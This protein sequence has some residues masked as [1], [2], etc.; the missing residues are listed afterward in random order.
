MTVSS[1]MAFGASQK[2]SLSSKLR[3]VSNSDDTI[4]K[5]EN[6]SHKYPKNQDGL[7]SSSKKSSE[8]SVCCKFGDRNLTDCVSERNADDINQSS[9]SLSSSASISDSDLTSTDSDDSLAISESESIT[10]VT[11]L[12]SPYCDSPL[13]QG[14]SITSSSRNI[15][16][17]G[18][19][20]NCYRPEMNVLMKAVEK[21]EL[22]AKNNP[23]FGF[24]ESIMRGR[25]ASLSNEE[26]KRIDQE[27]QRLFKRVI[28]QQNRMKSMYATSYQPTSKISCK[29]QESTK[30]DADTAVCFMFQFSC[31]YRER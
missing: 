17:D 20:D 12:N 25:A 13:P 31:L 10:D 11:P 19:S 14:K 30:H 8:D 22:E 2:E 9:D 3:D 6:M 18:S 26:S 27:N 1:I 5:F 28:A 24:R 16:F 23:E 7:F 15:D 29:H 4:R 21:L